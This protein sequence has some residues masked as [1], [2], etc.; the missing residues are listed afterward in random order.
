PD[1]PLAPDLVFQ[2]KNRVFF[3]ELKVWDPGFQ[4]LLKPALQVFK[5]ATYPSTHGVIFILANETSISTFFDQ[6]QG[7]YSG[8]QILQKV[9]Q[10]FNVFR[11]KM[12]E[13]NVEMK[14]LQKIGMT[15]AHKK[16]L[17]TREGC[18]LQS[19][20]AELTSESLGK[21]NM[22]MQ[23]GRLLKELLRRHKNTLFEINEFTRENVEKYLSHDQSGVIPILTGRMLE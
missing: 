5:Y 23:T 6:M 17:A 16:E 13:K 3:V 19:V 12:R 11:L 9:K 10:N 7:H 21:T 18:I 1:E 20:I 8:H 22:D 14:N 2:V 15:L 4:L